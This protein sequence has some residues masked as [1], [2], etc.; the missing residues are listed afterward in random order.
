MLAASNGLFLPEDVALE[1]DGKRTN[2][3]SDY[4]IE[5]LKQQIKPRED[6]MMRDQLQFREKKIFFR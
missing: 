1:I 6:V 4:Q 5:R 3:L 2:N